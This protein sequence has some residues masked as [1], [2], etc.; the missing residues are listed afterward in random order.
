M[1]RQAA[2]PFGSLSGQFLSDSA[3]AT[4]RAPPAAPLSESRRDDL[5]THR[6]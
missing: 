4:L 3:G 2:P 5:R 1:A 6:I